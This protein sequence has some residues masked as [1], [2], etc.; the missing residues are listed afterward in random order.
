MDSGGEEEGEGGGSGQKGSPN[1]IEDEGRAQQKVGGEIAE[2]RG[3][4]ST[5]VSNCD[6]VVEL[7]QTAFGE[8]Q[9]TEEATWQVVV[10]LLKGG[11]GYCGIVLMEVMW[12]VVVGISN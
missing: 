10:L 3:G 9:L 12:K 1:R 2:S 6:M 8:G 7:V 5:E 11:K 4:I